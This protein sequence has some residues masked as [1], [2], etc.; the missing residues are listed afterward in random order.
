MFEKSSFI[1][2]DKYSN[3]VIGH[4]LPTILTKSNFLPLVLPHFA[5]EPKKNLSPIHRWTG[6]S[7]ILILSAIETIIDYNTANMFVSAFAIALQNV[8]CV[9]PAFVHYGSISKPV[10][11]GIAIDAFE[12]YSEKRFKMLVLNSIPYPYAKLSALIEIFKHRYNLRCISQN[13][14][15]F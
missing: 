12:T 15:K 7:Q 3:A 8:G 5:Y 14:F 4:L 10:Y 11:L 1:Q 6:S 9:I 13:G 2:L